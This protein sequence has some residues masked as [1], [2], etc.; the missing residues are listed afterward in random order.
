MNKAMQWMAAAGLGA[1]AMYLLDPERGKRR[2]ATIRDKAVHMM[3]KSTNAMDVTSRDFT[4]RMQGWGARLRHALRRRPVSDEMLVNR[5][6]SSIGRSV[7]HASAIKISANQGRITVSGPILAKEVH[8]LLKKLYGVRGVSAVENQLEIYQEPGHIPSLQ[9]QPSRLIGERFELFQTN[10]SP[11]A[12]FVT[13]F[14]GGAAGI[15]GIA[16]RGPLGV[17]VGTAGLALMARAATNMEF[18]RLIGIVARRRAIDIQK[19]VHINAPVERVFEVW[20][21]YENFPTFMSHVKDI[22]R[23]D[24][25][26]WHWSVSGPLGAPVEWDAV[27][28]SFVPNSS[29]AWRSES[30][31]IIQ[32]AG[33]VR[34]QPQADGTTMVEVRLS[35][36]PIGGAAAHALANLLGADPKKQ[37]DEDLLRMKHYIETGTLPYD[38]AQ[39]RAAGIETRM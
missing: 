4:N 34:F 8:R 28:T 32:H 11:T 27:T 30:G 22:R 16:Q 2:R 7:S 21:K 31:S 12:R 5:V 38:I 15:Y 10:W 33:S 18:K 9:G 20:S 24:E 1:G 19:S 13:G 29:L 14:A 17:A 25:K 3:R 6:R 26:R 35:Y 37:M 39:R 23:I 36:N